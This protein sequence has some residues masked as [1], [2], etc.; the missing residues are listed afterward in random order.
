MFFLNRHTCLFVGV[1]FPEAFK[2]YFQ[3]LRSTDIKANEHNEIQ[4]MTNPN[5]S[6]N[7]SKFA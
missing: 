5:N 1:F 4:N 6:K 3:R 2:G 7:K